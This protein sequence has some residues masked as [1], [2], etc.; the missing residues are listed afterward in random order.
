[1]SDRV[2]QTI[3]LCEDDPQERLVRQYVRKC[4]LNS[5]P[6]IFLVRNSS[7]AT[8]QGGVTWVLK[9]FS[10][11][12]QA[13]RARNASRAKTLLIVVADA[14]EFTVDERRRQLAEREA[15][16]GDDPLVILIP[17]RNIETWIR[18]AQGNPTNETT[19]YKGPAL[20]KAEIRAAAY[21][22]WDW[23]RDNPS[24]GDIG[25]PSLN[26]SLPNW[27]RIG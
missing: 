23:A 7:R 2:S 22:I 17:R 6:P 21:K 15:I 1:M 27:R 8:R 13:C 20:N 24:P 19:D 14:D 25:V 10:T 18:V 5:D 16:G 9:Q 12:L 26:A 3:L 4:G 11:E